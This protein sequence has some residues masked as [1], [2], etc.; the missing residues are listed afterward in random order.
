MLERSPVLF[1][2]KKFLDYKKM[3][4]KAQSRF[5]FRKRKKRRYGTFDYRRS[6]TVYTKAYINRRDVFLKKFRLLGRG[7]RACG[8][9]MK[10]VSSEYKYMF[11]KK[12]KKKK[13]LKKIKLIL[14]PTHH[15]IK[16]LLNVYI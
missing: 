15:T 5:V 16:I 8:N 7:R 10:G 6:F 11:V 14:S 2:K 9:V 4:I 13:K 1:R 3:S 12:R